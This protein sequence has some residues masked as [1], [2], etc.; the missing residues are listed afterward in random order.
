MVGLWTGIAL[1]TLCALGIVLLPL[2]R[3]RRLQQQEV[4]EDR[5]RQNIDIY[6]ERLSELEEEKA[7]GNLAQPE[8]DELKLEL[9][10]SLLQDVGDTEAAL[11][12]SKI[13]SMQVITV[14]VM[15]VLL[16]ISSLGLYA[17][18]G[19]APRLE[20]ALERQ[21][22]P[23]PFEGRTPTL[24][25]ALSR[26]EHELEVTPENVEGWYLLATTYMGAG[27][28][29]D[30]IAAFKQV[31]ARLP[32]DAPQYIGVM[33]QYAQ[34]LYFANGGKMNDAVREQVAATLQRNPGEITAL[35][36]LGIDAFEQQ[37][38][39]EAIDFWSRALAQ[40]EP[41]AAESLRAGISRAQ[42]ELR[43]LGEPVPEVAGIEPAEIRLAVRLAEGLGATLEPDQ[44][45][46]IFARPVGGRMP[47]A[48]VKLKVSD[49]PLEVVLDDTLAMTPQARLSGVDEVEVGARI[50]LTGTPEPKA[51]DLFA[52]LSPVSVRGQTQAID[53]VIDQ[54]VE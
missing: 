14:S 5:D 46:F 50:S 38:Y 30:G 3:A 18:L 22:Q 10:R 21:A 19:S 31:L 13:S 23:D 20:L 11:R 16:V 25:E 51:G 6:R 43:A 48:A 28:Y 17:K 2:L 7:Q 27:R 35:G 54:V 29:D 53:L 39:A 33:G 4:A 49:L 12:V 32:Q 26:L 41:S 40:A 9:E 15:A 45:V 34:A 24:E 42:Q 47:L 52:I 1:L 36:L 37:R 8:F 44:A